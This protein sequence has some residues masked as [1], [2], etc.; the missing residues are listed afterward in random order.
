MRIVNAV[1]HKLARG[2]RHQIPYHRYVLFDKMWEPD[3]SNCHWCGYKLPW[4]H[5]DKNTPSHKQYHFVVCA[6]HLNEDT[7]DNRPE[8]LVPSCYWCNMNRWIDQVAPDTWNQLLSDNLE[9]N[10]VDRPSPLS[11]AWIFDIW[12]ERNI[13]RGLS[14]S[15]IGRKGGIVKSEA[16]SKASAENGKKGGRPKAK[17]SNIRLEQIQK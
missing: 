11:I 2:A 7:S 17:K 15:D 3:E 8:N 4:V 16:K 14:A 6:D 9:I 10:P 13:K 1:G 5:E 12:Q